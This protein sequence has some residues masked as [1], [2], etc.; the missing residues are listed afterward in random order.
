M[1]ARN[2]FSACITKRLASTKWSE[3]Q[4]ACFSYDIFQNKCQLAT[5]VG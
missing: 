5:I 3:P 1:F 4:K 2:I